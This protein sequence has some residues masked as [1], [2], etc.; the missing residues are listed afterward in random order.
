METERARHPA[1]VGHFRMADKGP[2]QITG[3][4]FAFDNKG[5]L[6]RP[7]H[8]DTQVRRFL[9]VVFVDDFKF[10]PQKTNAFGD[11]PDAVAPADQDRINQPMIDTIGYRLHDMRV[12]GEKNRHRPGADPSGF[13]L[14]FIKTAVHDVYFL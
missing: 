12:I 5:N 11:P 6:S 8:L 4:D 3:D 9:G 10:V 7:G 1:G 13:F 2:V 14:Y